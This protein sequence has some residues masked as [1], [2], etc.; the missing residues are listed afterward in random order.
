METELL[1]I[2]FL[3]PILI[4]EVILMCTH[5]FPFIIELIEVKIQVRDYKIDCDRRVIK[6]DKHRAAR[7]DS[8]TSKVL[9]R[10]EKAPKA[11]E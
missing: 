5:G 9:S 8:I 11:E 10:Y 4:P 2:I 7:W 3:W 1:N 6:F